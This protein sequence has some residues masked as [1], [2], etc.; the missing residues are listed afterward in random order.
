MAFTPRP[1][2]VCFER[3]LSATPAQFERDLRQ[4]WPEVSGS[5]VAG[6]LAIEVAPMR[7]ELELRVLASRRIALLELPQLKVC[8]AFHGGD[9]SARARLLARLDLAMQKGGG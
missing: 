7:L 2:P 6:R 1:V 9:E 3:V 8:Y 5:A 4:A